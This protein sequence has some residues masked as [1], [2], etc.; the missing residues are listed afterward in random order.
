MAAVGRRQAVALDAARVFPQES[1]V[2]LEIHVQYVGSS[3]PVAGN[4]QTLPICGPV[5]T[6]QGIPSL[7][8]DLLRRSAVQRK[9][10]D[11]SFAVLE[12]GDASAIGRKVPMIVRRR[13]R[14]RFGEFAPAAFHGVESAE[15]EL[16]TI[17]TSF[18]DGTQGCR[19]P[20]ASWPLFNARRQYQ[21][22]S[23]SRYRDPHDFLCCRGKCVRY[24]SR[25]IL[26]VVTEPPSS[27]LTI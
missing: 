10:L 3:L 9:N 17:S 11:S 2:A 18:S 22:R 25:M 16:F 27:R 4:K 7:R 23:S 13:V 6:R 8:G 24:R 19:G 20:G 15:D 26:F 14:I 1:R 12:E 5:H 21:L